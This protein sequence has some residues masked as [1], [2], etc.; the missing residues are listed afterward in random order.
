V[1]VAVYTPSLSLA[2]LAFQFIVET[3]HPAWIPHTD[4]S[5]NG[6]VGQS[7]GYTEVPGAPGRIRAESPLGQKLWCRSRT[8][9][10][11]WSLMLMR[12]K[13]GK[14][15]KSRS[16]PGGS[17]TS[18]P[19][20]TWLATIGCEYDDRVAWISKGSSPATR[21]VPRSR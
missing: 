18:P 11:E 1:T 14:P 21:Y 2:G 3:P 4:P 7:K 17:C 10:P 15:E 9:A 16:R 20:S 6:P 8:S 13:P 19:G 12:K 5:V